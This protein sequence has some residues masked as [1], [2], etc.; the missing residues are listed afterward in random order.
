MPSKKHVP[1]TGEII[2]K[3]VGRKERYRM[4]QVRKPTTKSNEKE[5]SSSTLPIPTPSIQGPHVDGNELDINL[6]I[7]EGHSGIRKSGKVG[8]N[9]SISLRRFM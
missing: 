4:V 5:A 8:N 1:T 2:Y 3:Q 9:L 6:D 7:Q